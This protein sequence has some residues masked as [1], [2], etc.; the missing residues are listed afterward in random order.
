MSKK[1]EINKT[2]CAKKFKNMLMIVVIV[3]FLIIGVF[4]FLI[5][6]IIIGIVFLVIN[7]NLSLEKILKSTWLFDCFEKFSKEYKDMIVSTDVKNKN[8]SRLNTD[9]KQ[10]I[11]KK[12]E[13]LA[14]VLSNIS[15]PKTEKK[16]TKEIVEEFEIK[17]N[18]FFSYTEEKIETK[19]KKYSVID[20][21]DSQKKTKTLDIK[22]EKKYK[23]SSLFDDKK[24]TFSTSSS[25]IW[26]N[27]DSVMDD[28]KK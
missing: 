16:Q 17:N 5:P 11:L 24:E 20:S 10:E 1:R 19:T 3:L 12:R 6:L 25:S 2:E 23:K 13:E 28:F 22:K 21:F 27:Y 9:K 18:D 8:C 14:R 4:P 15:S 26:D 7:K